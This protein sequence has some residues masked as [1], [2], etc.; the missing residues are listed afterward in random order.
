MTWGAQRGLLGEQMALNWYTGK[1][2]AFPLY[3]RRI[4]GPNWYTGRGGQVQTGMLGA[5]GGLLGGSWVSTSKPGGL[6]GGGGFLGSGAVPVSR[7]SFQSFQ[8]P[9]IQGFCSKT[10]SLGASFVVKRGNLGVL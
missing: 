10:Q 4:V 1:K 5:W 7:S 6:V 2:G 8:Y 9:Q 3:T